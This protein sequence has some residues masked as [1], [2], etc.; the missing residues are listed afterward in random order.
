MHATI[1]ETNPTIKTPYAVEDL[2]LGR[3]HGLSVR[4]VNCCAQYTVKELILMGSAGRMK[5]RSYGKTC[6]QEFLKFLEQNPSPLPP[7]AAS[8]E[9][10]LEAALACAEASQN[11]IRDISAAHWTAITQAISP[12]YASRTVRSL[13]LDLGLT[14]PKTAKRNEVWR[15]VTIGEY[16]RESP[17]EIRRRKTHGRIKL[18][19][20]IK[21]ITYCARESISSDPA[22]TLKK[23]TILDHQIFCGLDKRERFVLEH[24][25]CKGEYSG[26]LTLEEIASEFSVTRE[27]IR[28]VEKIIIDAI[29]ATSLKNQA[30]VIE[31]NLLARLRA[32]FRHIPD[33]YESISRE[34]SAEEWL[35]IHINETTFTTWLDVNFIKKK[36]GWFLGKAEEFRAVEEK[37]SDFKYSLLP[38]PIEIV[39]SIV[40][41]EAGVVETH[42]ELTGGA[43][44]YCG[45]LINKG[46][47]RARSIRGVML[48]RHLCVTK[49]KLA[50][51]LE[52][53][54]ALNFCSSI[55][56][57]RSLRDA[58][59]NNKSILVSNGS[60][61][62]ALRCTSNEG[63]DSPI[64]VQNIGIA[65][66]ELFSSSADSVFHFIERHW[67]VT[68]NSAIERFNTLY[69]DS[70]L[71]DA[72][73]QVMM[74]IDPRIRRLSPGIYA[75]QAT[76]LEADEDRLLKA[77]KLALTEPAIRA[78]CFAKESGEDPL[79][80][81]PLWDS[82]QEQM[83]YRW[84][85]K[86][87]SGE[88][89]DALVYVCDQSKWPIQTQSE[90]LD[91]KESKIDARF[92]LKP[93]W[94]ANRSFRCP[95]FEDILLCCRHAVKHGCLS[96]IGANAILG[97]S[98]TSS[99][100]GAN[101][102][103]ILSALG[104]LEPR[105]AHWRHKIALAEGGQA[106]SSELEQ[107]YLTH[108]GSCCWGD[109]LV[110]RKI[111]AAISRAEL[112]QL[113][114]IRAETLL[115]LSNNF[116]AA[117]IEEPADFE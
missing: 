19:T 32:K 72:S 40:K 107:I 85:L 41:E 117:N 68:L 88:L 86:R 62:F 60:F 46:E 108:N 22:K 99:E 12:E 113:G 65:K 90:R 51:L 1:P 116:A 98:F 28:Q 57:Y 49:D 50:S 115:S 64:T 105:G 15:T 18:R 69:T 91:I 89:M 42:F 58:S 48:H 84:L 33:N 34:I 52:V 93:S 2:R 38:L 106:Q 4:L 109:P 17:Q 74:A 82:T 10:V 47:G 8:G 97:G 66:T 102:V 16:L 110:K 5:L 29:K 79:Q 100:I 56:D 67:P 63:N 39:A 111:S 95:S 14:W 9:S 70:N 45:Y 59:I 112:R 20:I 31:Q 103:I 104:I 11:P 96:W 83:W 30:I 23:E 87:S 27:R 80:L 77:R 25:L 13:A 36:Q 37:F 3:E 7:Q 43:E 44:I 81:F 114:F 6:E 61:L 53:G 92:E 54:M 21:A 26:M 75:P 24:R 55:T 76:K 73:V 94:I 35:S 101:A 78:Y 71:N